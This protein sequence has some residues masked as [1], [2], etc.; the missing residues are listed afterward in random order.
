M[1]S[2][3]TMLSGRV[4]CASTHLSRVPTLL[5]RRTKSMRK[6]FLLLLLASPASAVTID[7]VAAVIDRQVITVSEVSQMVA[8][9]F[10]AREAG[11]NED[12]YR[13]EIL[14]ALIAQA[15]RFRDVE[16]FGAQDISA[17]VIE[18]RL[19]EIQARFASEEEFAA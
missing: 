16:R 19:Q 9:R 18:A 3:C 12:A 10:F 1:S 15:L 13:R 11:Q 17:D 2:F 5:S 6:L 14:D 8:V 7:R 4:L